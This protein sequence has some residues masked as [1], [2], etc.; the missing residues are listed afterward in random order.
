MTEKVMNPMMECETCQ[1]S[2]WIIVTKIP[3]GIE[4]VERCDLCQK[5][6][7]DEAARVAAAKALLFLLTEEQR[8]KR[9]SLIALSTAVD[10]EN[11]AVKRAIN[12]TLSSAILGIL[13][14]FN[15]SQEQLD[16]VLNDIADT[17]DSW[18]LDWI[19]D[20]VAVSGSISEPQLEWR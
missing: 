13:E 15:V 12:S 17:Y 3:P 18:F 4:D 9:T 19:R 1:D 20:N 10:K 16:K 7:S 14:S 11:K 8:R 2:G 5:F 6:D